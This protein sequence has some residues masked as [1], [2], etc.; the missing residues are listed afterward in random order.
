MVG[1]ELSLR[2]LELRQ[3]AALGPARESAFGDLGDEVGDRRRGRG[4]EVNAST[5]T[6]SGPKAPETR[7][8]LTIEPSTLALP[9]ALLTKLDQSRWPLPTAMPVGLSPRR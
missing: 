2:A 7:L 3:Q 9:I 4:A 5:A 6:P 8:W 1:V